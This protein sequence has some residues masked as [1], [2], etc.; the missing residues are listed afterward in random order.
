MLVVLAFNAGCVWFDIGSRANSIF[1]VFRFSLVVVGF[2]IG[3]VPCSV[4]RVRFEFWPFLVLF[5][6]CLVVTSAVFGFV[7]VVLAVVYLLPCFA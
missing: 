2:H 4:G 6:L 5:W 1:A 3:C 7:S